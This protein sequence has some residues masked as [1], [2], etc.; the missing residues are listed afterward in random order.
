[1]IDEK[2]LI[3]ELNKIIFKAEVRNSGYKGTRTEKMLCYEDVVSII[4]KQPKVS[5]WIPVSERLPDEEEFVNA[6]LRI[7]YAA[8]FIVMIKGAN[9]PTTLYFTRN[10]EWVDEKRDTYDVIA[11]QPLPEPYQN[12]EQEE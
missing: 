11:W 3:E 4:N 7:R 1:M 8:E 2:K 6:Y 9:R 10:G 12:D 5:E